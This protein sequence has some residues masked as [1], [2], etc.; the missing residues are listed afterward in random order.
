MNT[1]VVV[2]RDE[3]NNGVWWAFPFHQLLG[4]VGVLALAGF[5]TFIVSPS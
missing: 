4:T 5:L 3:G 1:S 2:T